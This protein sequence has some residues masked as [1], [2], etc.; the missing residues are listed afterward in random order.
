MK[1]TARHY[2][3]FLHALLEKA[4]EKNKDAAIGAFLKLLEKHKQTRLL[5]RIT[6]EYERFLLQ[7]D[8]LPMLSVKTRKALSEDTK[9][10]IRAKFDLP[11]HTPVEESIDEAIIGG[12]VIKYNNM[13]FDFSLQNRLTKLKQQ[14][15]R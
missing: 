8:A 1:F 12:L 11:A 4:G 3:R 15:T 9:E 2:A 13:L 14:L 7:N 6:R 5:E 10:S